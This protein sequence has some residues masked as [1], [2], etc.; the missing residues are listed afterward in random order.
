MITD[1]GSMPDMH[2]EGIL[3]IESDFEMVNLAS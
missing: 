2:I 1:E 3:L